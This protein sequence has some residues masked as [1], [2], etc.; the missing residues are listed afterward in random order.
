MLNIPDLFLEAGRVLL[1]DGHLGFE[2]HDLRSEDLEPSFE[3]C[4]LID[5]ADRRNALS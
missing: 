4:D 2:D 5:E 1:E 3:D